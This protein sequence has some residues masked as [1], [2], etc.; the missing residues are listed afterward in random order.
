MNQTEKQGALNLAIANGNMM[1][2]IAQDNPQELLKAVHH[3]EKAQLDIGATLYDVEKL[4]A[5]EAQAN[6]RLQERFNYYGVPANA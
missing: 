4:R 3:M 5:L 1:I 6:V 2:A